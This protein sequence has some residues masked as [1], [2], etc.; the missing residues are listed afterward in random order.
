MHTALR[1]KCGFFMGMFTDNIKLKIGLQLVILL[2]CLLIFQPQPI[3]YAQDFPDVCQQKENILQNCNFDQGMNHW[4]SFIETG[5]ADFNVLQGG[6]EC[7][8]PLCPAGYMVTA[9]HF[10][11][12]IL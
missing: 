12:G 11:G 1:K 5:G 8:A 7:H 6:G 3:N 2:V 4:Q 10:V 9:D